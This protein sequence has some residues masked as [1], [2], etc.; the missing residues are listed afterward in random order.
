[1]PRSPVEIAYG[2]LDA[3]V[4]EVQA[5]IDAGRTC[6]VDGPI[7]LDCIRRWHRDNVWAMWQ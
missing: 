3:F 2:S 5:D 7:I 1:M 6:R 4:A